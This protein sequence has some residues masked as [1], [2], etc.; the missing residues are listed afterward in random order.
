MY[1]YIV[2]PKTG[3]KVSIYNKLGKS[4]LQNY[5][6]QQKGGACDKECLTNIFGSFSKPSDTSIDENDNRDKKHFHSTYGTITPDGV[7]KLI[8]Y[9][10]ITSDDIFTDLGSG[11][12]NVVAQFAETSPIKKARG[13]EFLKSRHN[14][15]INYIN[16]LNSNKNIELINGDIYKE[17][18]SDSTIVF[19]CST[20]FSNELM[21]HIVKTLENNPNLKYL[22][23]QKIISSPT[24]L[25][26]LGN[27]T[28][29]TSW[30][31]ECV[32]KIYS[33]TLQS[34]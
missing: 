16:Q 2:N 18:Y 27:I 30:N 17:D 14:A 5:F 7:E 33:N 4:I 34:I 8:N 6:N 28:L 21:E 19:M 29:K 24:K 26:Y 25:N 1:N 22:I 20:C 12:G 9:L 23:T 32:H 3:R 10:N 13:I 15:A 31:P 11:I